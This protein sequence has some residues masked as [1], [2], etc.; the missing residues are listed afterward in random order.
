ML[1]VVLQL[2]APLASTFKVQKLP[3]VAKYYR[4]VDS[5]FSD[6]SDLAMLALTTLS[7]QDD[8]QNARQ[9]PRSPQY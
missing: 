5:L 7:N 2:L 4:T 1:Y 6:S 9:E 8:T 3:L